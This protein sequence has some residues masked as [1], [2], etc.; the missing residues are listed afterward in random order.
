MAPGLSAL[1]KHLAL[2]LTGLSLAAGTAHAGPT[3]FD[4]ARAPITTSDIGLFYEI[5][6]AAGGRPDKQ[7]LEDYLERGSSGV[8]GYIPWRIISADNL[9]RAIAANPARYAQARRCVASLPAAEALI[10]RAFQRL[11][12]LHPAARFPTTYILIGANNS[13][14]AAND[15][16]LMIGLEV[17]CDPTPPTDRTFEVRLSQLVA[18]EVVHF[19]Q[20]GFGYGTLLSRALNEGTAEFIGAQ[21]SGDI[22]NAHLR[23]WAAGREFEIERRFES[24]M[25]GSDHR[26]WLYNGVGTREAPGDLGYWVGYRIAC[27][28]Y[29]NHGSGR[30]AIGEILQSS[31]AAEFLARSRW[32]PG[33]SC[34]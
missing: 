23:E 33:A 21:I 8:Q 24:V 29:A 12:E 20:A 11:T 7:D 34:G 31:K 15:N 9:A 1:L 10:R 30:S 4:A 19:N 17:I 22:L 32:R 6:D 18:H 3:Y 16:A 25:N 27:S 28:Y 13:G 14:G 2:A 26:H 5:Y